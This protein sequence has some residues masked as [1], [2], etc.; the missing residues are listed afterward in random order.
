M[1]IEISYFSLASVVALVLFLSIMLPRAVFHV[2]DIVFGALSGRSVAVDRW[3]L[4]VGVAFLL[5]VAL[6]S[7]SIM[8]PTHAQ[9]VV[10]RYNAIA[11]AFLFFAAPSVLQ[12]LRA[13][14]NRRAKKMR[15]LSHAMVALA[16]ISLPAS[17][18][19]PTAALLHAPG[20][21]TSMTTAAPANDSYFTDNEYINDKGDYP[22]A[23][24]LE[25]SLTLRFTV[26]PHGLITGHV[27]WRDIPIFTAFWI[28][29][30]LTATTFD[31]TDAFG[32][33]VGRI[34]NVRNNFALDLAVFVYKLLCTLI[35]AAVTFDLLIRPVVYGLQR[36]RRDR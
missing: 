24:F 19:V 17:M 27:I 6:A 33:T 26:N 36:G 35:L 2:G 31:A 28:D 20:G 3:M 12:V 30:T 22:I 29:Q 25:K 1:P 13:W 15:T 7:A 5:C 9:T 8:A 14:E 34:T 18:G 10:D 11:L 32:V 4:A 16:I 21:R 23:Q